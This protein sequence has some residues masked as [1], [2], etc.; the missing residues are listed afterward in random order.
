MVKKRLKY[1]LESDMGAAGGSGIEGDPTYPMITPSKG[2]IKF[3]K[4]YTRKSIKED[5]GAVA[6]NSAGSGQVAGIGVNNPSISNQSEPGG[7]NLL[8]K[9]KKFSDI[10]RRKTPKV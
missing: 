9:K 4:V 5:G 2:P 10:E 3:K 6:V 8:F 7:R 1:Y